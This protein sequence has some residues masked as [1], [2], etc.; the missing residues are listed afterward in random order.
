M[1]ALTADG[2]G[3]AGAAPQARRA[4]VFV[5]F[6]GAGKSSAARTAAAALG[7]TAHDSDREVE[8]ALGEAIESFFDREGEAAF[9]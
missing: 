6:M 9:R 8:A 4:L 5:G 3:S 1:E 2:A 7:V